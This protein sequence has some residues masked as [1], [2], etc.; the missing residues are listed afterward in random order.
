MS[1]IILPPTLVTATQNVDVAPSQNLVDCI[2][3]EI[4]NDTT[5]AYNITLP[6]GKQTYMEPQTD[7]FFGGTDWYGDYIH[8]VPAVSLTGNYV[9]IPQKIIIIGYRHGE[10]TPPDN[11]QT[12][13]NKAAILGNAVTVANMNILQ[14]DGAGAGTTIIETTVAGQVVSNQNVTNDGVWN[15]GIIIGGVIVPFF[16]SKTTGSIL[17]L[18]STGKTV[19][20]MGDLQVDG[21]ANINGGGVNV[22]GT[23][24]VIGSTLLAGTLNANGQT[25]VSNINILGTASH[26]GLVTVSN[27]NVGGTQSTTGATTLASIV[28]VSGVT[29]LASNAIVSGTLGVTGI[30]TLASNVNVGGTFSTTGVVNIPSTAT[31][32]S[33]SIT[34]NENVTGTLSTTGATTHNSTLVVSGL[35]TLSNTNVSGTLSTTGVVTAASNLNVGGTF[36]TTGAVALPSTATIGSTSITG[37]EHVNGSLVVAGAGTAFSIT[38]SGT[39]GAD[40]NIFGNLTLTNGPGTNNRLFASIG[41]GDNNTH[42]FTNI[43]HSNLIVTKSDAVT[44]IATFNDTNGLTMAGA[45]KLNGATTNKITSNN[46]VQGAI[47]SGSSSSTSANQTFNHNFDSTNGNPNAVFLID[48][49]GTQPAQQF[50][51]VSI[52]ST[53]VTFKS[54]GTGSFTGFALRA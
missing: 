12:S 52:T 42:I 46:I 4:K 31:I 36:S 22:A 16:V 29:T 48:I 32:G 6:G 30:T 18:G 28:T 39:I 54:S 25:V 21:I 2:G 43:D 8:M 44:A 51:I 35:S 19:E 17:Q 9:G 3:I 13:I 45:V 20:V 24:S 23:I 26:I 40:L 49:T 50:V 14:N 53:Q 27:L 11:S 33:L 41:S 7:K 38:N 5:N 10:Q 47:F 1:F 37:N 34:G 15:I